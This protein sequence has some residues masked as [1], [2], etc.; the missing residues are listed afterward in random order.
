[1]PYGEA[2]LELVYRLCLARKKYAGN[3]S[4][5]AALDQVSASLAAL[6]ISTAESLLNSAAP[7]GDYDADADVDVQ[8]FAVWR[9]AAGRTTV[10][11][12]SGADGNSDGV[13]DGADYVIWRAHMP[14]GGGGLA[15]HSVPEPTT[16]VL[17]AFGGIMMY[18]RSM[19][20]PHSR[21]QAAPK[22]A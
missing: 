11:H 12:G 10:L 15:G 17:I 1:V 9:A 7:V 16:A 20:D 22:P 8:D 21:S 3:S 13:V 6:E 14:A 5:Q 2:E 19:R 18:C 4:V